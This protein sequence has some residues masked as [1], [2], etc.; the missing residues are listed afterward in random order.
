MG[1]NFQIGQSWTFRARKKDPCPNL[2]I[3]GKHKCGEVNIINVYIKGVE[4]ENAN[5]KNDVNNKIL[6]IAIDENSLTKDLVK[7]KGKRNVPKEALIQ[8]E[9][10]GVD[11]CSFEK[12]PLKIILNEIEETISR[13]TNFEFFLECPYL[14]SKNKCS[15][16]KMNSKCKRRLEKCSFFTPKIY[17]E[18]CILTSKRINPKTN[19][20][21][22]FIENAFFI[23]QGWEKYGFL[24]E[25]Y[26]SYKK[27]LGYY[28]RNKF[29]IKKIRKLESIKDK[30]LRGRC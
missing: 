23:G 25:A 28:P 14:I 26:K 17:H 27:A 2:I 22:K 3:T 7:Y 30:R 19:K 8:S 4:I 20:M 16:M 10:W 12:K 15:L 1:K 5:N 13:G 24:G 21:E 9:S 18:L 6:H 11:D 29:L